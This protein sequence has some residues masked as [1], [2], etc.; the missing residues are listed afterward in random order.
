MAVERKVFQGHPSFFKGLL[1][2]VL[3]HEVQP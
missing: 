1:Y 2:E 3:E